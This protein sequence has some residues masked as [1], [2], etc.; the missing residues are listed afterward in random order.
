MNEGS[1]PRV[2]SPRVNTRIASSLPVAGPG[3]AKLLALRPEQRRPSV[4]DGSPGA[5][6]PPAS[7][8]KGERAFPG[9]RQFSVSI[10]HTPGRFP[11]AHL[12]HRFE[13]GR[14]GPHVFGS[15]SVAQARDGKTRLPCFVGRQPM[16]S[17]AG[18]PSIPDRFPSHSPDATL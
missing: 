14:E 15:S 16:P 5:F 13:S 11:G 17:P 8:A 7:A 18:H 6:F 1:C 10:G 3:T 2:N 4:G 9:N 12:R